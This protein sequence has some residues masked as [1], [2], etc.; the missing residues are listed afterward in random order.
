MTSPFSFWWADSF[1]CLEDNILPLIS[2]NIWLSYYHYTIP[3]VSFWYYST[4]RCRFCELGRHRNQFVTGNNHERQNICTNSDHGKSDGRRQLR[5]IR[6]SCNA[7]LHLFLDSAVVAVMCCLIRIMFS[8][9]VAGNLFMSMCQK[10]DIKSSTVL[11]LIFRIL[12]R[13]GLSLSNAFT[14]PDVDNP[15]ASPI[16]YDRVYQDSSRC[17]MQSNWRR[18][19]L[20]DTTMI[21]QIRTHVDSSLQT[22]YS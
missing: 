10:R 21:F 6:Y 22:L 14:D 18:K 3:V 19:C 7:R 1:G 12:W 8:T 20:L 4:G 2:R 15:L 17:G 11:P 16:E 5:S 9:V 13:L